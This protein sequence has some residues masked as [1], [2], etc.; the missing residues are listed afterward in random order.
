MIRNNAWRNQS[1]LHIAV[2]FTSGQSFSRSSQTPPRGTSRGDMVIPGVRVSRKAGGSQSNGR[3]LSVAISLPSNL[4]VI[5]Q[6]A[7]TLPDIHRALGDLGRDRIHLCE[8]RNAVRYPLDLPDGTG[9]FLPNI[10]RLSGSYWMLK[11]RNGNMGWEPQWTDIPVG[12][13]ICPPSPSHSKRVV[14]RS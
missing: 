10:V 3:D 2:V 8:E 11:H 14:S 4:Q 5:L 6:C 1:A 12:R 7:R 9:W 13:S